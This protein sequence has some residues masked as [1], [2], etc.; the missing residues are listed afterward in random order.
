M[1]NI[2]DLETSYIA[3]TPALNQAELV[4]KVKTYKAIAN[5]LIDSIQEANEILL[6]AAAGSNEPDK[7]LAASKVLVESLAQVAKT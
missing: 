4:G 3:S 7:I 5:T 2:R 6:N 1:D